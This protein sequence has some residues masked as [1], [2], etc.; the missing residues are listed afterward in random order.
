M[1]F[2]EQ[3]KSSIDDTIKYVFYTDDN[4]RTEFSFIRKS[5]KRYS[6]CTPCQTMCLEG[7]A[8]CHTKGKEKSISFPIRN[9]SYNEIHHGISYIIEDL[10]LEN[11]GDELLISFM[12]MG[13]PMHNLDAVIENM[14]RFKLRY[15]KIR[16]ALSTSLPKNKILS[17]FKMCETIYDLKSVADLNVK[18]HLSLHSVDETERS[19]MMPNAL[20]IY[21]SL[22]AM[23]FYNS[24]TENPVEIQFIVSGTPIEFMNACDNLARL[25]CSHSEFLIKFMPLNVKGV[26]TIKET[27]SHVKEAIKYLKACYNINSEYCISPGIDIGSSCGSFNMEE[28]I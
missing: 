1:K 24:L 8:M 10:F 7:C 21:P 12:G 25:I 26:P 19:L 3:I 20:A 18:L 9:L 17:F 13:E 27:P 28:Y 4:C 22:M 15:P 2:R 23:K 5:D 11:A 16:L 6:I 14:L